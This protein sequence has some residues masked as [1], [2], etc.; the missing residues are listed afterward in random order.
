MEGYIDSYMAGHINTR[1]SI[2]GY[3]FTFVGGV[4][5]WQSKMQ[6][7]IN[8]SNSKAKTMETSKEFL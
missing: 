5:S 7:C 4:V 8:L 1:K 3:L 2:L 6:K